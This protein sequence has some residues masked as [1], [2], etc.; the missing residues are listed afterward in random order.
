MKITT[1]PKV[2]YY[3]IVA[4]SFPEIYPKGITVAR[5]FDQIKK[6]K[7]WGYHFRP[8]SETLNH[9]QRNRFARKDIVLTFDDGF[10]ANYPS[11]MYL[12]TEL[13][14]KPTLFLIG[15]C[16]DNRELAWN[17]KLILIKQY[18]S[19]EKINKAI[20]KYL[21]NA[22]ITTFFSSV[23]MADKDNITDLLWQEIMPFSEKEFLEKNKPFLSLSQLNSLVNAGIELGIHS[24]SHPDFGRLTF[25]EA[26]T[27]IDKCYSAMKES[28][29]PCQNYFA[30]PYGRP[31]SK[32][33]ETKLKEN[34]DLAATFGIRYK[35][36]DNQFSETRWQRIKMDGSKMENTMQF[37]IAPCLRLLKK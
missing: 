25:S 18:C 20:K 2:L 11:L 3:H 36:G 5:F 15:K 7:E 24:W 13:K 34:L 26:F 17:H 30:Y 4:D 33:M 9:P 29:L 8:L 37:L 22:T 19:T 14:I 1:Y 23:T 35:L 28:G 21:P 12:L 31:A 16:I 10:A 6:L 32:E 27:E